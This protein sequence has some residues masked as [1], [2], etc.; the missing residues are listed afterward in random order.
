M[1]ETTPIL[2]VGEGLIDIDKDL[3]IFGVPFSYG[4]SVLFLFFPLSF[5]AM[6]R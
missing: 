2:R 4:K 3:A 6:R 1:Y 5:Q